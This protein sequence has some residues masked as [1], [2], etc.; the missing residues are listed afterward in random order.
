LIVV[1]ASILVKL[2]KQEDDSAKARTVIDRLLRGDEAYL[3]PTLVL[4]EVLSAA[5]HVDYPFAKVGEF[6]E[7]LRINGLD[8]EEPTTDELILAQKIASTAAPS[9]GYPA[10]FDSI[11]HAMAMARGAIFLTTDERHTAK[12]GHLG[13]VQL[14]S[15]WSPDS[16][17]PPPA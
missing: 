7:K 15:V 9:G 6:F 10:L 17:T 8:I 4:Y 11:Y 14:L 5:L 1:D 13:S 3:A 12:A 16:P 2:F